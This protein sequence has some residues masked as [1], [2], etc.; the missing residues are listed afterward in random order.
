[1]EVRL[2]K[3]A[4]VLPEVLTNSE[5]AKI[6]YDEAKRNEEDEPYALWSKIADRPTQSGKTLRKE[7][8]NVLAKRSL[9]KL[10]NAESITSVMDEVDYLQVYI[11]DFED[12][13][14]TSSI[15]TTY[16]PLTVD[17]MDIMEITVYDTLG[18][19]VILDVSD[20]EWEPDYAVA[21]VGLNETLAMQELIDSNGSQLGKSVGNKAIWCDKIYV[22]KT[23]S[24]ESWLRGKLEMVVRKKGSDIVSP[25]FKLKRKKKCSKQRTASR[26]D[27]WI[28]D[29]NGVHIQVFEWD[30]LGFDDWVIEDAYLSDVTSGG[31]YTLTI[32]D[33]GK[34]YNCGDYVR[35][36]YDFVWEY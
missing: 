30:L 29:D 2:E 17:D 34:Y 18:Q 8:Q 3:F 6:V 31:G 10:A 4:S 26:T 23:K 13:D 32:I 1:M 16:T 12:W 19:P 28:S 24:L 5:L 15:T 11:H 14:G 22:R 21:V 36:D 9:G 35:C 33:E 20:K 27:V 25:H 7:V